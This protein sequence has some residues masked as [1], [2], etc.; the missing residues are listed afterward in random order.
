MKKIALSA[1][2]S[3]IISHGLSGNKA[4]AARCAKVEVEGTLPR[5]SSSDILGNT[6][7]V[8]RAGDSNVKSCN[9]LW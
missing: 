4:R 1:I 8:G 7:P 6:W 5:T 3:A 2:K 9:T